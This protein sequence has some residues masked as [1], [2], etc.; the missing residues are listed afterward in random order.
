MTV[1]SNKSPEPAAVLADRG[2]GEK[3]EGGAEARD[4][5][6]EAVAELFSIGKTRAIVYGRDTR[7]TIGDESED[8]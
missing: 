6:R 5:C 7:N 8:A 4:F 3:M 2:F 1:P